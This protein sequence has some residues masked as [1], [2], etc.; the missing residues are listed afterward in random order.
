MERKKAIVVF[1]LAALLAVLLPLAMTFYFTWVYTLNTEQDHLASFSKRALTRTADAFSDV[2]EALQTMMQFT[3]VPCSPAHIQQ[4]RRVTINTSNVD[5]IGYFEGGYLKCTSWGYTE[6]LSPQT[7][8]DF[9]TV[10]GLQV[11][12]GVMPGVSQGHLMVAIHHQSYNAL[13]NPSR[14]AD[15]LLDPGVQLA[16]M[17]QDGLLLDA[18]RAPQLDL[19]TKILR[20]QDKK[21]LNENIF[22]I[23]HI[24]GLV[25]IAIEPYDLFLEK[26]HHEQLLLLPIGILLSALLLGVVFWSARKHFSPLGELKVAIKRRAFAVHYQP[27]LELKTGTCIGAEAL[28][29]WQRHD[30]T[31]VSPDI[32]IPLAEKYN[33]IASITDQVI[34]M[35]MTDLQHILVVERAMH[36][37]INISAGDIGSGRILHVLEAALKGTGVEPQQI[38]LEATERGF[39][40]VESAREAMTSA[41]KIGYMIAI[42][43][44]GTGYSSL[45]YLENLPLDAL[46]IDK[47]FI[48]GIDCDNRGHSMASHIIA[49][50]KTLGLK[51]VAE[52]IETSEQA[53][54]LLEHE[55]DY[56]QGWLY[57]KAMP[58]K[59]YIA[60]YYACKSR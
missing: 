59:E 1:S 4:M 58:A 19:L 33:L 52:G 48:E 50:A 42:D 31:M 2:G 40:K 5:E 24:P 49:M 55:V 57:A 26:L 28:I 9:T 51:I 12:L 30:G 29:R 6:G 25:A 15:I 44:F 46:K 60:F 3:G 34:S 36:I 23:E 47:S 7:P 21:I 11:S 56:G 54:Y 17:T 10:D 37:A 45:S 38:W 14:F 8:I 41:R 20:F 27:L 32:F 18:E 35:I 53:A 16:V 13:V 22:A 39:L 43:D